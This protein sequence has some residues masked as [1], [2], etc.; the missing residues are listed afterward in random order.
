MRAYANEQ[1][2]QYLQ[3]AFEYHCAKTGETMETVAARAGF[4]ADYLASLARAGGSNIGLSEIMP[5][6]EAVPA[7]LPHEL[8][9]L[10]L[11][12]QDDEELLRPR[13]LNAMRREFAERR[14]AG[15]L[16]RGE[17]T[18][19]PDWLRRRRESARRESDPA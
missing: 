13:D 12:E 8:L 15:A 16:Q 3:R 18:S 7:L 2:W 4:S 9:Y 14:R 5:L 11:R 17:N 1:T 6:C 19:Y 10:R